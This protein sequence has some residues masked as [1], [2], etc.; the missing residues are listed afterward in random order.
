[1]L[2]AKTMQSISRHR[3]ADSG[4]QGAG[5][6]AGQTSL[7]L[8]VRLV[9]SEK[10]LHDGRRKRS[11]D[12]WDRRLR[13]AH[14]IPVL[15][16]RHESTREAGYPHPR[17]SARRRPGLGTADGRIRLRAAEVPRSFPERRRRRVTSGLRKG[18]R[19]VKRSAGTRIAEDRAAIRTTIRLRFCGRREV[20]ARTAEASRRVVGREDREARCRRA[21][22]RL[23]VGQR[24]RFSSF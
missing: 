18:E 8:H 20:S 5:D 17:T 13:G 9:Q 11:E 14:A 1:M 19:V 4:S 15:F 3:R 2:L 12:P 23:R 7:S 16:S 22:D 6:R 24:L 10:P 21:G